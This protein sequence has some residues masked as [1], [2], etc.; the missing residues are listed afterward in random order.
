MIEYT[1]Y[2]INDDETT[3][4]VSRHVSL[5]EGLC[6]AGRIIDNVDHDF[7]YSLHSEH[8]CVATFAENRR[9]YREWAIRSSRINPSVED[10]YDHDV[11][12]LLM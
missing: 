12:E 5:Q 8:G 3:S 4:E 6:E 11:D 2:R 7:A 9:Y 1:L 10:R